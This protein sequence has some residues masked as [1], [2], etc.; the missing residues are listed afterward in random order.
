MYMYDCLMFYHRSIWLACDLTLTYLTTLNVTSLLSSCSFW[1]SALM[2]SIIWLPCPLLLSEYKLQLCTTLKSCDCVKI[3]WLSLLYFLFNWTYP[4]VLYVFIRFP[5]KAYCSFF[6]VFAYITSH[7]Y[8]YRSLYKRESWR[9]YFEPFQYCC[10]RL[11]D[12]HV[13]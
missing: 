8:S 11:T 3:I 9:F 2:P 4:L 10:T 5:V 1:F 7:L 12:H 6:C 13:Q